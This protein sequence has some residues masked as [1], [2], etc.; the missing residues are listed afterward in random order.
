MNAPLPTP[1]DPTRERFD[2]VVK[3][4]VRRQTQAALRMRGRFPFEASPEHVFGRVTDP[5]LIAGWFGMIRSGSVDHTASCN[6]GDWG[7]GSKRLCHTWGMGDLDETIHHY[8]APVTCVYSVRSPMMPVENHAAAM[9][10]EPTATGCILDWSQFFDLRGLVL[11]HM[12]PTM[13][14]GMMNRG[15]RGLQKELGG[16]GGAMEVVG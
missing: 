15:L 14:A 16:N 3:R 5:Q 9:L 2:D 1:P 10:L 7:E 4:H 6:V 11:K 8:E 12:F 13:M